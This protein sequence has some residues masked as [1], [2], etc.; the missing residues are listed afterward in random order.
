MITDDAILIRLTR[1]A[2]EL[3]EAAAF[4]AEGGRVVEGVGGI[5]L[6][7][8]A[9]RPEVDGQKGELVA[10]DYEAYEEMA[11]GKIRELVNAADER[12]GVLRV[13]VL[14]RLGRVAVGEVSVIIGVGCAHRNEA[15]L[16]CRYL[17]DELKKVVPIWKKEVYEGG[18]R[19]QERLGN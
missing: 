8:G 12:W 18:A 1:D 19:W 3:G 5:N 2:L 14:H 11:V 7:L 17:I 9:T 4:L 6:F 15:F 16:A 10:L 13:V